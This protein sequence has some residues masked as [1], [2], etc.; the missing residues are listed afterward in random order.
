MSGQLRPE[1]VVGDPSGDHLSIRVLGR[2][3]PRADNFWDGNW[4]ATPIEATVGGFQGRV[5]ASL[6]ADELQAFRD[7]LQGL[8][9]ALNG[10]AALESMEKWLTLRIAPTSRGRLDVK[11]RCSILGDQQATDVVAKKLASKPGQKAVS[12]TDKVPDLALH[13]GLTASPRPSR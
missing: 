2:L 3:H 6:R 1:V 13:A 10:D 12:R 11:E 9:S 4:L 7:A 8:H 5:G